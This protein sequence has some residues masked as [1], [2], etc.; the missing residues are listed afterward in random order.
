MKQFKRLVVGLLALLVLIG[1]P[2][3]ISARTAAETESRTLYLPMVF[4]NFPPVRQF[5]IE[6]NSFTATGVIDK[7]AN[8]NA[9]WLRR[10]GLLWSNVQPEGPH[11]YLW[12]STLDAELIQASK[13][14]FETILIV[15]STPTWAQMDSPR[16]A[17]CAPMRTEHIPAFANFMKEVV[18]RYSASP[19]NVRHYELWNEPDVDPSLVRLDSQYGCWGDQQDEY[20]GGRYYAEMLKQVYPAVKSANPFAQVL[21]GGLLLDCDPRQPGV[22]GYCSDQNKALPGKFFEG[23]L[24]NGGGSFFDY[25]SFHGYPTYQTGE[26]PILSE[27]GF[28]SWSASGGVVAGKINYLRSVMVAYG[29]EKPILHTEAALLLPV[30]GTPTPAFQQAKADYAVWLFARN[31]A[32]GIHGTTWYTLDGPGWRS[33]SLLDSTQQPLPAY[34]AYKFMADKLELYDFRNH[35]SFSEGVI[36]FEFAN[37]LSKIW[38]LFTPDNDSRAIAKPPQFIAAYDL[39]GNPIPLEDDKINI[40]RP[41]FVELSR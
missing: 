36:G 31:W 15:R 21:I 27:R 6:V 19:Y 26:N 20:Y 11:Q 37:G 29:L 38:V 33:S 17:Y 23:I 5:G 2:A 10:N 18:K 41:T 14:G 7:S 25:V 30:A 35:V 24:V 34:N 40:T 8:S 12:D 13:N 28:P 39:F 32:Q 16:N 9:Y 3:N 22:V 4:N 1:N